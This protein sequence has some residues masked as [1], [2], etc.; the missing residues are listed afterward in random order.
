MISEKLNTALNEQMNFEFYS[1]HIYVQM[2]A[3]A[4]GEGYD[5]IA[6]FFLIQAEEERTHAMKFYNYLADRDM[7]ITITGFEMDSDGLSSIVHA[8]ETALEHEKIVTKNIYHLS[9]IAMD[10]REHATIQFLTWF[11]NEQVEEEASFGKLINTLKH[12]SND[13]GAM[14]SFDEELGRR[15]FVDATQE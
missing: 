13:P 5:G 7:P 15:V 1:A 9:D 8:F 14:I 10:E 12:I 2:A 11:L 6:N 4:T 3:Y